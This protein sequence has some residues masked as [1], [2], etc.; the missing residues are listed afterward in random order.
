[1]HVEPV[2]GLRSPLKQFSA[3]VPKSL[4]RQEKIHSLRDLSAVSTQLGQQLHQWNIAIAGHF[5]ACQ[6]GLRIVGIKEIGGLNGTSL[7]GHRAFERA[8]VHKNHR[9][10]NPCSNV[11]E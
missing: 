8:T 11:F 3:R 6:P 1:V 5:L 7:H 10:R 4:G 2:A 9:I